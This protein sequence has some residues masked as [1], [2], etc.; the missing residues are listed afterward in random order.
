MVQSGQIDRR[1]HIRKNASRRLRTVLIAAA[2]SVVRH[3]LGDLGQFG[4]RLAPMKGP[5]K[6]TNTPR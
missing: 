3:D 2:Y 1:G 4:R 5:A 6:S